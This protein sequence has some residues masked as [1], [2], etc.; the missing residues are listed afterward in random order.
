MNPALQDRCEAVRVSWRKGWIAGPSCA[1]AVC[2]AACG[3]DATAPGS[4]SRE[5]PPPSGRAAELRTSFRAGRDIVFL[6]VPIP[7]GWTAPSR[8]RAAPPEFVALR[9]DVAPKGCGRLAAIF[10]VGSGRLRAFEQQVRGP[11]RDVAVPVHRGGRDAT[12]DATVRHSGSLFQRAR[13]GRIIGNGSAVSIAEIRATGF[14]PIRIVASGIG[15]GPG[16]PG[17][18]PGAGADIDAALRTV[19]AGLALRLARNGLGYAIVRSAAR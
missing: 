16:C 14:P 18:A 1:L 5:P 8:S 13:D 9:R 4:G 10:V 6:R 15:G 12:V 11:A 2:L 3:A 19:N 7:V 17:G